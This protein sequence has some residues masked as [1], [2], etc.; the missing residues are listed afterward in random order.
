MINQSTST[1][2]SVASPP[3]SKIR[4]FSPHVVAK[5]DS[6][7]SDHYVCFADRHFLTNICSIPA[8]PITIPNGDSITATHTGHLPLHPAISDWAKTAKVLPSLK[9]ASLISF[10]KLS[11]DGCKVSMDMN[12]VT[13]CK[14]N[15][16]V[17]SGH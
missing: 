11:N 10:G 5:G 9:S 1:T 17:M 15:H 13:L 14:N 3:T 16:V 4:P 6:G 12:D 2:L 8:V 7:A